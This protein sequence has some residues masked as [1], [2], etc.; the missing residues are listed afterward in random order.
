LTFWA[1][2][3]VAQDK[4]E[5]GGVIGRLFHSDRT[6]QANIPDPTIHSGKGIT[7]GGEYARRFFVA[8]IFSRR[9]CRNELAASAPKG[10]A[11]LDDLEK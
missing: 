6:I 2:S 10:P 7:F 11:A 1:A 4:N 3:S 8:Q 9:L 5:I